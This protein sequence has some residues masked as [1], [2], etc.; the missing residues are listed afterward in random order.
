MTP[1]P[2]RA[3]PGPRSRW[4]AR[5]HRW[6]LPP[7]ARPYSDLVT[8]AEVFDEHARRDGGLGGVRV[9]DWTIAGC[10]FAVLG[11]VSLA[12]LPPGVSDGVLLA[13]AAP[14]ALGIMLWIQ[15]VASRRILRRD[16]FAI[17]RARGVPLCNWCGYDLGGFDALRCPECGGVQITFVGEPP[18]PREGEPVA[19]PA[20]PREGGPG[21]PP[22]G[23]R[24][25]G[26]GVPPAGPQHGGTGVPP[27][28][29]GGREGSA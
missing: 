6:R 25:G 14:A 7:E 3:R 18:D 22:A 19:P 9:L 29:S 2:D 5:V 16:A 4:L 23:S 10:F 24:E 28:R 26:T 12:P 13:V 11:I 20:G 1:A 8:P 21:V 27:V 17:L 15:A